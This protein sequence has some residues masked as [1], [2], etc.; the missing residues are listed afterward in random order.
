MP[1]TKKAPERITLGSGHVY[2]DEFEDGAEMPD[3][4]TLCVDDNI[5]GYIQGGATLS[6]KPEF[7][8]ASDDDGTHQKTIITS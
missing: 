1:G 4:D 5:L 8:T 3:V 2:Y 7:Y 6:Y